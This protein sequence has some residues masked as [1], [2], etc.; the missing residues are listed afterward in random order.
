MSN[1]T[2]MEDGTSGTGRRSDALDPGG[3]SA[4][5]RGWM[6]HYLRSSVKNRVGELDEL[7]Q[8]ELRSLQKDQA[9]EPAP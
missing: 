7:T 2:L 5:R 4:M 9:G 1:D 8:A 6:R 3:R